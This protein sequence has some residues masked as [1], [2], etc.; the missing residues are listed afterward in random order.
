MGEHLQT[1]KTRIDILVL[2]KR[3]LESFLYGLP[4]TTP[5]YSLCLPGK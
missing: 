4:D 2:P 3:S 5:L 1:S